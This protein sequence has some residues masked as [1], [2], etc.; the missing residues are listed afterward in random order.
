MTSWRMDPKHY[1]RYF[2]TTQEYS[3]TNDEYRGHEGIAREKPVRFIR[4]V[5]TTTGSINNGTYTKDKIEY[6]SDYIK[7][8]KK[9]KKKKG[10]KK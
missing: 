5:N 7:D 8:L 9:S 2:K 6:E 4:K 1:A 3:G 10:G